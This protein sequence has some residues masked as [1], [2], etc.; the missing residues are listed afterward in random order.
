MQ[1]EKTGVNIYTHTY[2]YMCICI[3]TGIFHWDII[4]IMAISNNLNVLQ[5]RTDW[6]ILVSQMTT[7]IKKEDV[8]S[9]IDMKCHF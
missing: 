3:Y 1:W 6:I 7:V 5:Q 8:D 4:L 2:T 9:H